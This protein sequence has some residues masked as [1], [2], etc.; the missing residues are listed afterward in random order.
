[1]ETFQQAR[2][3]VVKVGTSTLTYD[4]GLINI[5]RLERL[6]EVLSDLKNSGKEIVLVTSGAIGVGKGKLRLKERPATTP[7]RQAAAAVGQCELMYLYDQS[8]TRYNHIVGQ[9]LLTRDVTENP[10]LRRNAVNTF[11][12]LF[13]MGVIPIVNENDSVATDEL[14]GENFGDNDTL[15]AVVATLVQADVLV[16][17]SDIDGLYTSDPRKDPTAALIPVVE[18]IDDYIRSI[19]SGVG[20]NRGTGGM[21][22]KIHAAQIAT[23]AGIDMAIINGEKPELLYD[24]FEGK[25]VGTVFKAACAPKAD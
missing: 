5:R 4:T 19:A 23:A 10:I 6:V 2:R 13:E 14:E 18:T 9:M 3:V 7:E 11:E 12:Q 8:F 15:S 22:T 20:S 17:L 24:L 25:S 21:V 1:M 16:L